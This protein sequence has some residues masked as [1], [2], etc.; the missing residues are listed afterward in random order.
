MPD[1][2]LP[3]PPFWRTRYFAEEV[4]ARPDRRDIELGYIG[5]ACSTPFRRELQADGRFRHWLWV[6]D[7]RRWL[8]VII[9]PDGE[10][11]H[12]AFWDRNFKP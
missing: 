4:V 1:Q 10:T 7:R 11:V 2:R 3:P 12:N 8:R 5:R 6:A 9:E